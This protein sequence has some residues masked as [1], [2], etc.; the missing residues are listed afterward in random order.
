MDTKTMTTAELIIMRDA[1][2]EYAISMRTDPHTQRVKSE[3]DYLKNAS[4][5]SR[6]TYFS[7]LAMAAEAAARIR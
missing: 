7:A 2:K 4:S 5:H 1:L 6:A 3:A